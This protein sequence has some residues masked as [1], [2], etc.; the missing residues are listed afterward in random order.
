MCFRRRE[1]LVNVAAVEAAAGKGFP[2]CPTTLGSAAP[3]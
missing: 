3:A 1:Y 2:V